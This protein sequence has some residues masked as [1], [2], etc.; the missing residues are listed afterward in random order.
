MQHL[1]KT[2]GKGGPFF[3]FWNSPLVS[4]PCIQAL[5]FHTHACKGG[6]TPLLAMRLAT[7]IPRPY[8]PSSISFI[9]TPL[10]TL[11]HIFALIK[12][13]TLLFSISSALFAK[14]TRGWGRG[15]DA[16]PGRDSNPPDPRLALLG[17]ERPTQS[18]FISSL[19]HYLLTPLPL[20]SLLPYFLTS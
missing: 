14:N 19:P 2:R 5:S 1:Q 10:R 12:N 18:L 17:G 15:H 3:P 8:P 11:L 16:I 7:A 4:H 13:S 9:F 20:T 6:C